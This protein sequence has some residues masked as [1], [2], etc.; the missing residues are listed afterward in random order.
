MCVA[1]TARLR[2]GGRPALQRVLVDVL[3]VGG[4]LADDPAL[5]LGPEAPEGAGARGRERSQSGM[6]EPH[7]LVDRGDVALPRL[8]S[9]GR[10]HA[11]RRR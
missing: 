6:I 1:A 11:A 2:V 4:Q 7:H 3:E 5:A 9:A 8:A 10:A